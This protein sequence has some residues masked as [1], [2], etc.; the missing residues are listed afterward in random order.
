MLSR[1]AEVQA[2][3]QVTLAELSSELRPQRYTER[4]GASSRATPFFRVSLNYLEV[5]EDTDPSSEFGLLREASVSS[6]K[7]KRMYRGASA[8]DSEIA[9]FS[10]SPSLLDWDLTIKKAKDGTLSWQLQYNSELFK[11]DDM[12][13]WARRWQVRTI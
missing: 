4:N 13:E 9:S 8:G 2:H 10:S 11:N 12:L 1:W 5:G 7:A 3:G 6:Q